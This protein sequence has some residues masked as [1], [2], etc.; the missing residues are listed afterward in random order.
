[1]NQ[2]RSVGGALQCANVLIES[3]NI[4]NDKAVR[5]V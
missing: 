2:S 1:M 5:R 4:E 3:P